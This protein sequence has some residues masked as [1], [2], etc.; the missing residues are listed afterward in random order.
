MPCDVRGRKQLK[1]CLSHTQTASGSKLVIF[2]TV[3]FRHLPSNIAPV[4]WGEYSS[5][6]SSIESCA[7]TNDSSGPETTEFTECNSTTPEINSPSQVL[8][9]SDQMQ[10]QEKVNEEGT[11]DDSTDSK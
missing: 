4:V 9:S 3:A 10:Q 5:G 11:F 6:R 7:S 2:S 8:L 1:L